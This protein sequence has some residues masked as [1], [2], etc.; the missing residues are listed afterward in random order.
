MDLARINLYQARSNLDEA[1]FAIWEMDR[2]AEKMK[3]SS[4]D[5]VSTALKLRLQ[6]LRSGV[7]EGKEGSLDL[8]E[9]LED[10]L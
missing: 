10:S 5:M 1:R 3:E 8:E 2:Q 4:L 7:E 6:I 9:N